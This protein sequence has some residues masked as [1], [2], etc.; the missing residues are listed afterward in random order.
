MAR[1]PLGRVTKF[2]KK[3]FRDRSQNLIH[4]SGLYRSAAITLL[5]LFSIYL[6]NVPFSCYLLIF[7]L[8]TIMFSLARLFLSPSLYRF[9]ARDI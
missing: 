9:C 5:Y 8:L 1:V 2:L 4:A 7:H 3:D 6:L